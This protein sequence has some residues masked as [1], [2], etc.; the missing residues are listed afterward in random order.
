MEFVDLKRRY[1]V[2][3]FEQYYPAGGLED[4]CLTFDSLEDIKKSIQDPDYFCK[5]FG[6]EN[7]L[8][9]I[10]R[11]Y[12]MDVY[13]DFREFDHILDRVEGVRIENDELDNYES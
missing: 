12:Q 6:V 9:K 10:P 7:D 8:N 4:I 5:L 13:C 11:S 2:F 3:H 1:Y